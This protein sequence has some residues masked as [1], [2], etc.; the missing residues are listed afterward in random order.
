MRNTEPVKYKTATQI[1]E[2]NFL[3]GGYD[4]IKNMLIHP[5]YE[6]A[7]KARREQRR[8]RGII[9]EAKI[10]EYKILQENNSSYKPI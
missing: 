6:E 1:E 9:Q 10:A 5:K 8:L 2:T 4:E 7:L 3:K